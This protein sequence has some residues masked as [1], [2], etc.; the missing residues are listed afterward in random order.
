ML[1]VIDQTAGDYRRGTLLPALGPKL[2]LEA[3][4]TQTADTA[5]KGYNMDG[6]SHRPHY[7][8]DPHAYR[9]FRTANSEYSAIG[10][11]HQTAPHRN[12]RCVFVA[13]VKETSVDLSEPLSVNV[14]R[15]LRVLCDIEGVPAILHECVMGEK[16]GFTTL[17]NLEGVVCRHAFPGTPEA[18]TPGKLNWAKI[19]DGLQNYDTPDQVGVANAGEVLL[20]E[21]EAE[22]AEE[23]PT[24]D[25]DSLKVA[26]LKEIASELGLPYSGLKKAEL[27]NAITA[28]R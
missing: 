16:L 27:I 2:V 14:G 26:E 21:V 25:L 13:I 1:E 18:T 28:A 6:R 10:D 22:V 15:L 7:V 19:S 24:E 20:Y 23:T 17:K 8:L 3:T 9:I 4:D 11:F 5:I 12:S